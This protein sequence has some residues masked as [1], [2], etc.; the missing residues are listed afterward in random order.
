[1][2]LTGGIG[3]QSG[4]YML[5]PAIKSSLVLTQQGST[6][7]GSYKTMEESPDMFAI[8]VANLGTQK[9]I[10]EQ[11]LNEGFM[12]YK[13]NYYKTDEFKQLSAQFA[14]L[15]PQIAAAT[16][17]YQDY[18]TFIG[19]ANTADFQDK[20]DLNQ[21][22]LDQ[23]LNKTGYTVGDYLMNS[24]WGLRT[25]QQGRTVGW[26]KPNLYATS[27]IVDYW[28]NL[29]QNLG[30]VDTD[31]E[32]MMNMLLL[33]SNAPVA[34]TKAEYYDA[35]KITNAS[36]KANLQQLNNLKGTLMNAMGTDMRLRGAAKLAMYTDMDKGIGLSSSYYADNMGISIDRLTE[37][38][39]DNNQLKQNPDRSYEFVKKDKSGKLIPKSEKTLKGK[40][41]LTMTEDEKKNL[42]ILN[43]MTMQNDKNSELAYHDFYSDFLINGAKV[44]EY[45]KTI[46]VTKYGVSSTVGAGK[47]DKGPRNWFV[48]VS[49]RDDNLVWEHGIMDVQGYST[50]ALTEDDLLT[51][52]LLGS[53]LMVPAY[54]KK[55]I[56]KNLVKVVDGK[57]VPVSIV[58]F[59]NEVN[60]LAKTDK[61]FNNLL[62]MMLVNKFPERYTKNST[63][64]YVQTGGQ[65]GRKPYGT[66]PASLDKSYT[67][68]PDDTD[69]LQMTTTNSKYVLPTDPFVRMFGNQKSTVIDYVTW[70]PELFQ[71]SYMWLD[72]DQSNRKFFGTLGVP[73]ETLSFDRKRKNDFAIVVGEGT[74]EG[75]VAFIPRE[76]GQTADIISSVRVATNYWGLQDIK[77]AVIDKN[78]GTEKMVSLGAKGDEGAAAREA[79]GVI[80]VDKTDYEKMIE[81]EM[82]SVGDPGRRANSLN[83]IKSGRG[84][85]VYLVTLGMDVNDISNYKY[86]GK[87][88]MTKEPTVKTTTGEESNLDGAE[89]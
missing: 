41:L 62:N 56:E 45:N 83:V 26:Q 79:A 50:N 24:E 28:N 8:D 29:K 19:Y 58:N 16:H 31:Y 7:T 80:K 63:G 43:K 57:F 44:Y 72:L 5:Q 54:F 11:K 86:T 13:K 78:T 1:M 68:N 36:E 22:L 89:M 87:G 69:D 66:I 77:I 84:K 47:E 65:Q 73:I 40:D 42:G 27:D 75:I 81:D 30:Y 18:S 51:G 71:A 3:R 61:D 67:Y 37:I 70:E 55:L 9:R 85:Y 14:M 25:D 4:V 59:K 48:D 21:P 46:D 15:E 38:I 53:P 10:I 12:K 39:L 2:T 33:K 20:F 34:D 88:N 82:K 52:N 35:L 32:P 17:A 76:G 49:T 23:N 60:E 64:E 6:G 74:G